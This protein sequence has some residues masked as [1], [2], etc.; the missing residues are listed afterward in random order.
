MYVWVVYFELEGITT[1]EGVYS[2]KKRARKAFKKLVK[3]HFGK[4]IDIPDWDCLDSDFETYWL[5]KDRETFVCEM[6]IFDK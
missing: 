6:T 5:E 3:S 4:N 1:I 2:T